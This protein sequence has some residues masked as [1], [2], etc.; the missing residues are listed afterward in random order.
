MKV[1]PKV[2]TPPAKVEA[3]PAGAPKPE[4]KDFDSYEAY[5]E[6]L[7]EWN[8]DQR[9]AAKQRKAAEESQAQA[10]KAQK[11]SWDKELAAARERYDDFDEVALSD[12]LPIN[13]ATYE[14]IVNAGKDGA[15]LAYYLGQHRDE[16]A[17]IFKLSPTATM[18]ALGKMLAK[19]SADETPETQKPAAVTRAPKPPKTATGGGGADL[20]KEPDPKDFVKWNRWKDR[21]DALEAD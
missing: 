15:D 19:I 3:T 2:E 4:S 12:T 18:L 10:A 7:T 17:A 21:Q 8:I 20:G 14:T 1:E 11:E 16:A 9:E 5:I 13:Q 6:K